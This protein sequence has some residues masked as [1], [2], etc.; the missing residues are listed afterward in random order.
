MLKYQFISEESLVI[1]IT[2][3]FTYSMENSI[4]DLVFTMLDQN[5]C[6][7]IS[8]EID[9]KMKDEQRNNLDHFF[10]RSVYHYELV[11]VK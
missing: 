4:N 9:S 5:P 6:I 2:E 3:T 8:I 7:Q 10:Q 11:N 1:N